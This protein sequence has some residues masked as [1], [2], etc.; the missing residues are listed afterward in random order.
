M[1]LGD[2]IDDPPVCRAGSMT[3]PGAVSD[4]ALQSGALSPLDRLRRGVERVGD[5]LDLLRRRGAAAQAQAERGAQVEHR[6]LDRDEA[7]EPAFVA[8]AEA[9]EDGVDLGLVVG[10]DLLALP[11]QR[12]E[13]APLR[14]L[15]RAGVAHLFQ[16]GQRR[17]DDARARRIFASDPLAEL[18]DDLVAV[19]GLLG[20]QRQDHQPQ[21]AA[22]EHP[23]LAAL[24]SAAMAAAPAARRPAPETAGPMAVAHIIVKMTMEHCFTPFV[25]KTYHDMSHTKI[26]LLT[27]RARGAAKNFGPHGS[28]GSLT[29][30]AGLVPA[31]HA[32]PPQRL[33]SHRRSEL[34]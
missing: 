13:L 11:R 17:I 1:R 10:E 33:V 20:H 14:V 8:F 28:W 25:S 15:A 27:R 4:R 29:V 23:A 2:E 5:R 24:E 6:P 16:H 31:I 9:G 18:L 30:M 7:R 22:V 19:A 34:E 32:A 3:R 26:Y 21:F 12:I